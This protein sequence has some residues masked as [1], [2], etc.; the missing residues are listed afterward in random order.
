VIMSGIRTVAVM[1]VGI[2]TMAALVGAGGLGVL[3]FQGI[4]MMDNKTTLAG[5]IPIAVMAVTLDQILGLVESKMQAR[6]GVEQ[7]F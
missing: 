7:N 4:T 5:T 3:I 1:T 2:T 6:A